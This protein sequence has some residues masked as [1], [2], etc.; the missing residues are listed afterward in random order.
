VLGLL[1][2]VG[3]TLMFLM[4][5]LVA[6]RRATGRRAS[7]G[8]RPRASAAPTVGDGPDPAPTAGAPDGALAETESSS[9]P[10][11]PPPTAEPGSE[12]VRE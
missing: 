4:R 11:P 3:Q 1:L 7:E 9:S 12:G 5:I 6:D 10:P 8:R 2:F